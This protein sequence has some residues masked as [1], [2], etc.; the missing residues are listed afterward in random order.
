MIRFK[1][2]LML[3]FVATSI[4]LVGCDP[5][6]NPSSGGNDTDNTPASLVGTQWKGEVTT[7]DAEEN[8]IRIVST[9]NYTTET[10]G[11][12][13]FMYY[14]NDDPVADY[15]T[16]YSYTYIK[17]NGTMTLDGNDNPTGTVTFTVKG[18]KLTYTASDGEGHSQTIVYTRVEGTD[19]GTENPLVGTEWEGVS[20]DAY[21]VDNVGYTIGSETSVLK[22]LDE[23]NGRIEWSRDIPQDPS[24]HLEDVFTF[25]YTY[26]EY[27]GTLTLTA[28]GE[29]A[30][31]SYTFSDN[32][33]VVEPLEGDEIV[34]YRKTTGEVL[35]GSTWRLTEIHETE[36]DEDL[37]DAVTMVHLS[38][39]SGSNGEY[40]V[41]YQVPQK[42]DEDFMVES[43]FT[44]TYSNR[45]GSFTY[46]S[47][48]GP[49]TCTFVVNG[50][51]MNVTGPEGDQFLLTRI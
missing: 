1:S 31:L 8:E 3:A 16:G 22:F 34:L 49:E 32:K 2:L 11:E 25:T 21:F 20:Y 7:T 4:L 37:Y 51:Q 29:T 6:D 39:T 33:L 30:T 28:Y 12:V 9:L 50:D 5:E 46:D 15:T 47:E 27:E 44:Y 43:A 45:Q 13:R 38:F 23:S 10:R 26:D 41:N 35:E 40:T 42:P 19:P 17:P 36:I 48:G 24:G 18:N 14:E